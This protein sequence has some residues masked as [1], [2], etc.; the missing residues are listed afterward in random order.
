MSQ[1]LI[2]ALQDKN[3]SAQE[4]LQILEVFH[5]QQPQWFIPIEQE[6]KALRDM[7]AE[8]HLWDAD[9]FNQ[10]SSDFNRPNQFSYERCLHLI[11]VKA[12]LQ[13]NHIQGFTVEANKVS[14]NSSPLTKSEHTNT[15]QQSQ[16]T[17]SSQKEV[18]MNTQQIKNLLQDYTPPSK[19]DD[20][21]KTGDLTNI[22]ALLVT[23]INT[24]KVN[25]DNIMKM[26]LYAEQQNPNI[27]VPYEISPFSEAIEADSSKWN[28]SYFFSHINF[29]NKNFSRERFL[30]LINVSKAVFGEQESITTKATS[31]DTKS[32]T[33]KTTTSYTR[34]SSSTHTS[35]HHKPFS[36]IK[37]TE[38]S[39]LKTALMI[40]GAVAAFVIALIALK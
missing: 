29:L 14:A 9:Y 17:S 36:P 10:L 35:P 2:K 31:S 37:G 24:G 11:K 15:T 13:K 19:L 3:L 20:Y 33:T 39:I 8:E 27:F 32:A 5:Q 21:L 22:R 30:H 4:T 40:G 34:S 12:K 6:S 1:Q 25:I 38:N 26:G 16:P 28:Q 7:I 18:D 23:E